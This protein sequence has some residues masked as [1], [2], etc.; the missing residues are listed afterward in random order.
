MPTD[1]KLPSLGENI[2]SGDVVSVLVKEGDEIDANQGVLEIETDKAVVEVPAPSAGTVAKIYVKKGQTVKV[3]EPL[4][5]LEAKGGAAEAK[6]P[7]KPQEPAKAAAAAPA[8]TQQQAAPQPAKPQ[9]SGQAKPQQPASKP[10]PAPAAEAPAGRTPAA[11]QN[12]GAGH[13]APVP[14]AEEPEAHRLAAP[15]GPSTRRLARELGVDINRIPGTGPG[16]RI[17]REDVVAAVRHTTTHMPA[18][19]KTSHISNLPEGVEG[20]DNWGVTSRT[21]LSR[22]RKTIA[23]NMV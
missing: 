2:T 6:Q 4:I 10:K 12:G 16:G 13:R 18:A 22:I 3:G 1:F 9:P 5:A 19:G 8:K 14:E 20:H 11:G 17:T 15:A 23:A 7:A 21:Q